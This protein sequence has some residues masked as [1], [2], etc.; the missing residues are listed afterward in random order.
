M[1]V[2]FEG[3]TKKI[4]G[5]KWKQ[6]ADDE[7]LTIHLSQEATIIALVEELGR[8]YANSVHTPYIFGCPVDNISFADHLPPSR[9]KSA[10]DQLQ[11]V[12]VC[13]NCLAY[14]MHIDISTITNM[15]THHLKSATPSHVAASH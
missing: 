1:L 3:E 6:I 14:G 5:M 11:S 10:Q 12:V 2:E 13:L 9:L 15:L 8:Q 4:L 7:S